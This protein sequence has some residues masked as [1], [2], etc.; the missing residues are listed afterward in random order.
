MVTFWDTSLF[1]IVVLGKYEWT[2]VY[3]STSIRMNV[4]LLGGWKGPTFKPNV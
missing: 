1:F 4:A 3:E 2:S